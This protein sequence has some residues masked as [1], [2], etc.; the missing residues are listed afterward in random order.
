[1]KGRYGFRIISYATVM[2]TAIAANI[3][4]AATTVTFTALA[5]PVRPSRVVVLGSML[6]P[7]RPSSIGSGEDIIDSAGV[8]SGTASAVR[9][10]CNT[11]SGVKLTGEE[12][13]SGFVGIGS[14]TESGN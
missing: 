14:P 6:D 8:A 13:G 4:I 12:E 1:M 3:A 7:E 2:I 9:S 11:T 10:G 5:C